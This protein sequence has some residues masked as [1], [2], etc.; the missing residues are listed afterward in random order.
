MLFNQGCL[1][2]F[3]VC[4]QLIF[5]PIGDCYEIPLTQS[6]HY[7]ES[8]PS[9]VSNSHLLVLC[10]QICSNMTSTCL[11]CVDVIGLMAFQPTIT[12]H[13]SHRVCS[14]F[15]V[16]VVFTPTCCLS[17]TTSASLLC[18]QFHF[19]FLL[20]WLGYRFLLFFFYLQELFDL[21][22]DFLYLYDLVM[23]FQQHVWEYIGR[24][25]R[26]FSFSIIG[27]WKKKL[28]Q[29]AWA[30]RS[31]IPPTISSVH[32]NTKTF[33]PCSHSKCDLKG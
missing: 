18:F 14:P 5:S 25:R 29:L 10:M 4:K 1:F 3:V 20:S 27:P 13:L 12:S 33:S 16:V 7:D 2:L 32:S 21:L 26:G 11:Y 24:T 15:L 22:T 19:D 8:S 30:L 31:I 17:I 6:W 28:C 9:E 23:A